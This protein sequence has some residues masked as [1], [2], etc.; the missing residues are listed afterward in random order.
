MTLTIGIYGHSS[1]ENEYRLPIH[2]SHFSR[3]D[4]ATARQ[5]VVESGYGEK[6]G[7][8]DDEIA[9]Y[10]GG[11]LQRAQLITSAHIHGVA[12]IARSH[13]LHFT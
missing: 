4:E 2:P 9:Q 13:Q 8:T 6:F 11:V 7:V 3:I 1:L 10:V 5:L 12:Q